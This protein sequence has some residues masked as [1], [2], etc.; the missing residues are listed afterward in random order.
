MKAGMALWER[1]VRD[2]LLSGDDTVSF[3]L[4]KWNTCRRI[5]L[6]MGGE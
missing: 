1:S 3:S 4:K 6:S 2:G 5:S